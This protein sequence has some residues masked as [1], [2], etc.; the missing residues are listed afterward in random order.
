MLVLGKGITDGI[1][2]DAEGY[3][4]ARYSAFLPGVR[5]LIEHE[6][7]PSIT[8]HADEMRRLTE[9]YV[10]KALDGQL[11]CQY[12][13]NLSEA[14]NLCRQSGFTDEL[15]MEML[16]EREEFEYV[17]QIDE[18]C[19]VTIAEPYL[20]QED[21]RN[22][23]KLTPKE[24]EAM[25]AKHILCLNDAGGEQADF[26]NCL[27]KDLDLSRKNLD[28]A[29]FGGAIFTNTRFCCTDLC[30]PVLNNAKFYN[31]NLSDAFAEEAKFKDVECIGS[32]FSRGTFTHSNFAGARFRDCNMTYFSMPKCCI[33]GTEFGNLNLSSV[34]LSDCSYDEQKWTEEMLGLSER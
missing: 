13:I 5:L 9:K 14:R 26:S 17:E 22:L 11:D 34:N 29:V 12:R 8:A 28:S 15:F 6:Q 33:E 2:V 27:L 20:R 3:G 25:C 32:D 1:L 24:V 31:C 19:F 10:Q 30:F 4:Y 23:K 21:E 16:S 18:D 7:Y